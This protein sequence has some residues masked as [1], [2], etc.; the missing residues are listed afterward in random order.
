VA[1]TLSLANNGTAQKIRCSNLEGLRK[2]YACFSCISWPA[3]FLR[4]S[5]YAWTY[6]L[7]TLALGGGGGE[8]L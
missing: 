3:I 4:H 5:W 7:Q 1:L 8:D 2:W 6:I